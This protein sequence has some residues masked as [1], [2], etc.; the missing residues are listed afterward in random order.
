MDRPVKDASRSDWDEYG[1]FLGLNPDEYANKEALIEAAD[2]A[3]KEID[4]LAG[5]DPDADGGPVDQA[6]DVPVPGDEVEKGRKGDYPEG[7][8]DASD[9]WKAAYD[10]SVSHGNPPK[11]SIVFADIHH[12]SEEFSA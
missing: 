12:D 4:D 10:H 6:S 8:E 3:E 5:P 9:G 11:T 7:Y 1:V 2:A